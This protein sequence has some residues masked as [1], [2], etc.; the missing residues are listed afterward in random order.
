M[1]L[2]NKQ[3][4]L[5][6]SVLTLSCVLAVHAA[7]PPTPPVQTATTHPM[8]YYLSSSTHIVFMFVFAHPELLKGAMS[9]SGG[10]AGRGVDEAHIPLVNSAERAKLEIKVIVGEEDRGHQF[11]TDNW[12]VTK[13]KLLSYGHPAAKLQ[14]EI[15]KKGNP[16]KL[17]PSHAWYPTRIMDF[18]IGVEQ[19]LQK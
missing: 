7:T 16:E 19:S 4:S 13:T 11:Y 6:A 2:L 9:N 1:F 8:K 17:N 12:A 3:C 15:I 18:I 5:A 14:M 10:Y